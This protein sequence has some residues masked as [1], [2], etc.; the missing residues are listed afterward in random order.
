MKICRFCRTFV[1]HSDEL[2]AFAATIVL[3]YLFFTLVTT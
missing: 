2:F 3:L 1:R